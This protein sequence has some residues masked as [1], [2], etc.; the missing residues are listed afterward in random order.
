M[1]R[2]VLFEAGFRE[3]RLDLW[4]M[5]FDR[6]LASSRADVGF[7]AELVVGFPVVEFVAGEGFAGAVALVA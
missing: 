1:V 4:V 5:A 2:E 6:S 3:A 7:V